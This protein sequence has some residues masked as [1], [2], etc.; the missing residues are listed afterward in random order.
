MY[1]MHQVIY[2]AHVCQHIACIP[3]LAKA[4]ANYQYQLLSES[5]GVLPSDLAAIYRRIANDCSSWA[6]CLVSEYLRFWSC[7]P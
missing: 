4:A 5:C 6:Y 1:R 2:I 7:C 3:P